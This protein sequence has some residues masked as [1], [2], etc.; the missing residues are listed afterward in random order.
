MKVTLRHYIEFNTSV[1]FALVC[2]FPSLGGLGATSQPPGGV[3]Q[4]WIADHTCKGEGQYRTRR[5]V[6]RPYSYDTF[7]PGA[8]GSKLQAAG[9]GSLR[10]L[11]RRP[12]KDLWIGSQA[13]L[14]STRKQRGGILMLDIGA[15]ACWTY[16]M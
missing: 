5:R 6:L 8:R 10:L 16:D 13:L 1:V 4:H 15:D 9:P 12:R 2:V 3:T 14:P 7:Q 11:Q